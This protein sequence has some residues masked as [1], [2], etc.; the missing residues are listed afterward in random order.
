MFS[1]VENR[2][3]MF[4][5][6]FEAFLTSYDAIQRQKRRQFMYDFK[7]ITKISSFC[8][9]KI[10]NIWISMFSYVKNPFLRFL[11]LI[12]AFMTSYDATKPLKRCQY[13]YDFDKILKSRVFCYLKMANIWISMFSYAENLFLRFLG[14]FEAFLTSYDAIQRQKRRQFMYYFNKITKI[15][16]FCYLKMTNIWIS[17]FFYAKNPFLGFLR[18]FEAFLT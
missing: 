11:R 13:M 15:K 2:F 6:L 16:S 5:E 8:Y 17:M 14:L 10:A 1:Y 3:L 9:L 12:E 18:L 4:L 7:K